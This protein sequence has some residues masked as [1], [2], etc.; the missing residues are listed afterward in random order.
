MGMRG[1]RVDNLALMFLGED[2]IPAIGPFFSDKEDAVRAINSC[3]VDFDRPGMVSGHSRCSVTFFKQPDGRYT[4][5]LNYKGL[6]LEA[7]KNLDEL[8]LK[9]FRK[10][11]K[12]KLFVVTSFYEG[13]NGDL[14][15]LALTQGLGAVLV[16]LN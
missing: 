10:G 5:I 1:Y 9:R 8:M 3:L 11:L 4:L 7:L 2:N 6:K 15:C 12:K 13:K 16:T 14:E